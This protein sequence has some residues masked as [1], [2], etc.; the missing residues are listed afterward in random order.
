MVCVSIDNFIDSGLQRLCSGHG[1]TWKT[2]NNIGISEFCRELN[3]DWCPAE[4]DNVKV[5][6]T[7]F[8]SQNV[9]LKNSKVTSIEDCAR[10]L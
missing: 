9:H 5:S 4:P 3:T 7:Y 6:Y 2:I 10:K 8:D 1:V